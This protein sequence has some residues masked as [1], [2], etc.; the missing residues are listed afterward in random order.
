M[1]TVTVVPPPPLD[2]KGL[3]FVLA[4]DRVGHYPEFRTF[5]AH[6]FDLGR[7]GLAAPGYLRAPSGLYYALVSSAA[8]ASRFLPGSRSPSSSTRWSR[9]TRPSSTATSGRSCA[10]WS[11]A[12]VATGR[13]PT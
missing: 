13:W 2:G 10:G 9:S 11:P 3:A 6:T 7:V 8:A 4:E 1:S 12:P 5:L